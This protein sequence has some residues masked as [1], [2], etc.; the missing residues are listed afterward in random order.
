MSAIR[1]APSVMPAAAEDRLV[2]K[3]YK[4]EDSDSDERITLTFQPLY[5]VRKSVS[6]T[7]CQL[8]CYEFTKTLQGPEP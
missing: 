8:E 4:P 7:G 3:S 6:S 5:A 2:S 1:N